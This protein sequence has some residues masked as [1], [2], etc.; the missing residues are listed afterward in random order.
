M[1]QAVLQMAKLNAMTGKPEEAA[2]A[3]EQLEKADPNWLDPHVE[4]AALYYRLHRQEDG[5]REREIVNR[6]EAKQRQDSP[7]NQ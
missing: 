1:P 6:L 4:L 7:R 5:Q 3:L 2:A